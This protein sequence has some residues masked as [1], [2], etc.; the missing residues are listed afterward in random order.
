MSIRIL[1]PMAVW[2]LLFVVAA[3]TPVP[4][5]QTVEPGNGKKGDVLAATGV[6][7]EKTN[8]A[9]LFLTDGK[10]DV[11]AEV[12]EQSATTIKFKVPE[13]KPGRYNLMVLTAGGSPRYVE[14]PV[15]V[16]VE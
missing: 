13:I 8:L 15:K 11:K 5:L 7:L 2:L 1:G 10:A 3:Q 14:Q 9:E 12:T 6:N 16:T 4:R